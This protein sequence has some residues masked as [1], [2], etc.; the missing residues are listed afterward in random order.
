MR[1]GVYSRVNGYTVAFCEAIMI[2]LPISIISYLPKLFFGSLLVLISTDLMMEWLV[3]AH[4]KMAPTEFGV[5][6]LTFVAIQ[7]TGIEVGKLLRCDVRC[8]V[9]LRSCRVVV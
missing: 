5:C 1:R 2:M 4:S 3:A 6:L 7:M 9:L 8:Y